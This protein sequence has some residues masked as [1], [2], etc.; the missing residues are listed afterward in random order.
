[1]SYTGIFVLIC[2]FILIHKVQNK[3]LDVENESDTCSDIS[4]STIW[5]MNGVGNEIQQLFG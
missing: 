3:C 1:M 2:V 5:S 4:T